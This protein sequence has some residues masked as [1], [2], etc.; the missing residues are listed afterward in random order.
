MAD[1]RNIRRNG[2]N[3]PSKICRC[4]GG[5]LHEIKRIYKGMG[6]QAVIVWDIGE[7]NSGLIMKFDVAL[8]GSI[9]V[10]DALETTARTG[11][12]DWGDGTVQDYTSTAQTGHMY[13]DTSG[14][15]YTVTISCPFDSLSSVSISRGVLTEITIPDGISSLGESCFSAQ[16]HLTKVSLPDSITAMGARCFSS[17]EALTEIKLPPVSAIPQS[18]FYACTALRSVEIS[19]TVTVV[20]HGAFDKCIALQSVSIPD[21]VTELKVNA[22]SRCSG[23]LNVKLSQSLSKLYSTAFEGCTSLQTITLPVSLTYMEGDIFDGC[24][25][26]QTVYYEGSQAQFDQI[27]KWSESGWLG[28][29]TAQLVCLG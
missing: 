25:A 11:K 22:F 27:S 10:I 6:G 19:D 8:S 23:L 13:S 21:S 2:D 4:I 24:T 18:C 5:N 3:T 12:I 17:C 20:D 9:I 15:S 7:K 29:S 26:L 1:I 28:N 16:Y 14:A